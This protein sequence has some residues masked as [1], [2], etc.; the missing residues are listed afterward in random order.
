MYVTGLKAGVNLRVSLDLRDLTHGPHEF[1]EILA[2]ARGVIERFE[3]RIKRCFRQSDAMRIA[4]LAE[5][6]FIPL[7]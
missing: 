3:S 4:S 5:N 1:T 2:V 7:Q 6:N